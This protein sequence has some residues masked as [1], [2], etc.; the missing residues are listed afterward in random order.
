MSSDDPDPR[1]ERRPT[2]RISVRR[3]VPT[4]DLSRGLVQKAARQV[5]RGESTGGCEISVLLTDD[6]EIHALNREWR[7]VD[8]PT[9]VLSFPLDAPTFPGDDLRP[10]GDVA[11]SMDTARR[12]AETRRAG[13]DE[14]VAHL[15]VHG[16]LHLLGYDHAEAEEERDM[17][18]RERRALEGLGRVPVMWA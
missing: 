5:L 9:D 4:R 7:G 16:V 1:S 14:V 13:L 8:R 15:M 12:E 3:R 17:R 10:L 18:A 2:W 6:A 11:I